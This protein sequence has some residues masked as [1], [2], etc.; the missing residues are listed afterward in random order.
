[1][2][3]MYVCQNKLKT[4]NIFISL[5]GNDEPHD[6]EDSKCK[7]KISLIVQIKLFS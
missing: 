4:K 7:G 6:D 1:M 5:Q 3:M 2:V